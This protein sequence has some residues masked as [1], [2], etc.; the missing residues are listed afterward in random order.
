MRRWAGTLADSLKPA[1]LIATLGR[2]YYDDPSRLWNAPPAAAA[3][4]TRA[5]A[6]GRLTITAPAGYAGTFAVD[7]TVSDGKLAAAQSF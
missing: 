5:V 4:V 3:P 1:T 2:E 6:G 7:V